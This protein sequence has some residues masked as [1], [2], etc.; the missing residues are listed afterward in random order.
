MAEVIANETETKHAERLEAVREHIDQTRLIEREFERVSRL[1]Q[2][3]I[4]IHFVHKISDNF[5]IKVL[6]CS[7]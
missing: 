6:T 5:V 3:T 2:R 1:E 7:C 4:I